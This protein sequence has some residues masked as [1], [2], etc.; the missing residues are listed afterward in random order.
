LATLVNEDLAPRGPFVLLTRKPQPDP[1]GKVAPDPESTERVAE[2]A[3]IFCAGC[4]HLITDRRYAVERQGHHNHR[5]MNPGGFLY[6]IGCFAE[7]IG[8]FVVG[9][10]S[11][12][13]P[14]FVGYSW[15]CA[16]C[17]GCAHH[18]GWQFRASG[19][20]VSGS[21]FGLILDRV[22]DRFG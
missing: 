20:G 7:A 14:W 8:C 9:P 21:F 15:R 1:G 4:G 11:P 18:L 22:T 3:G 6:R 2:P 13:Y 10:D 16:F 19:E 12:E 5:F 17:A